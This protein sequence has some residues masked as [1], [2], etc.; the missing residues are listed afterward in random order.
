MRSERLPYLLAISNGRKLQKP[1]HLLTCNQRPI[2]IAEKRIFTFSSMK[3]FGY[4]H[5]TY[6]TGSPLLYNGCQRPL[7]ELA[8]LAPIKVDDDLLCLAQVV[9]SLVVLPSFNVP[10]LAPSRT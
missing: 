1:L 10:T 6:R 2:L 4:I 3:L 7:V 8:G 5:G 9:A